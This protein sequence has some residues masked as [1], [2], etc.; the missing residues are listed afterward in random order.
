[1]VLRLSSSER[2]HQRRRER[3]KR[4][5]HHSDSLLEDVLFLLLLRRG[6]AH[7]LLPLV[8]HH[9]LH[10]PARL[11]VQ[12]RQLGGGAPT[13]EEAGGRDGARSERLRLYLGVLGADLLGVDFWICGDHLAPPLHLVDLRVTSSVS[14]SFGAFS[15]FMGRRFL[16]SPSGP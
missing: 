15:G 11:S 14:G 6:Q 2:K 5:L 12:V 10:H 8:V 1:M 16:L 3:S 9:L 13:N 4:P 7:G